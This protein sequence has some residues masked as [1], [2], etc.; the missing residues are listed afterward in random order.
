MSA[1]AAAARRI[2]VDLDGTDRTALA[3]ARLFA[4]EPGSPLGVAT[5]TVD[6]RQGGTGQGGVGHRVLFAVEDHEAAT[7]LLHRRGET[8]TTDQWGSVLDRFPYLGVTAEYGATEHGGAEDNEKSGDN[9]GSGDIVALDHV[10][11]TSR[12]RDGAVALCSGVL[13][14]DFRL[15]SEAFGMRQLFFRAPA[16]VVEVVLTGDDGLGG[17]AWRSRDLAATRTRLLAAG[18][19]VSEIRTGRKPG[20]R[21]ATVRDP[22]LL[23]PTLL[24]EQ[25]ERHDPSASTSAAFGIRE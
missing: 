21:V 23:L 17:L 13:G 19:E 2:I 22:E 3:Y 7:R 9:E 16:T 14:L 6:V 20:T 18:C 8:V 10:V 5:A 24:L 15:D 4:A 1:P 25:R 11:L 12:D